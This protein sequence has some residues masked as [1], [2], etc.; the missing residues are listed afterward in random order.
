MISKEFVHIVGH[1]IE[2]EAVLTEFVSYFL[3]N[4]F[5]P[6]SFGQLLGLIEIC[7]CKDKNH[8]LVRLHSNKLKNSYYGALLERPSK[9]VNMV[10]CPMQLCTL[11]VVCIVI[12]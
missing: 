5:Y 10:L 9:C 1:F 3:I 7:I 2:Y 4:R 11:G 12:E 6:N 8:F